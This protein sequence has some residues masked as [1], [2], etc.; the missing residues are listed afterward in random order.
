MNEQI[1]I[2]GY[3]NYSNNYGLNAIVVSVGNVDIYFSYKTIIAFRESGKLF[4][5]KNYWGNT[6]GKYLNA[7]NPNKSIRIESD[8]FNAEM[9]RMLTNHKLNFGGN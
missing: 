7:I 2:A 1:T 4:I 9:M 3:G 6:T 5:S 8:K